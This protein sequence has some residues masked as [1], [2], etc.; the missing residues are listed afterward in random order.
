MSE[1]G[2]SPIEAGLRI[3]RL[4]FDLQTADELYMIVFSWMSSRYKIEPA[5][6]QIEHVGASFISSF[7][8]VKRRADEMLDCFKNNDD[9]LQFT[10]P[11][12]T[13]K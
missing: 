7:S 3:E 13:S 5:S 12:D 10:N 8:N 4:P 6:E 1:N 9:N 2:I 11:K